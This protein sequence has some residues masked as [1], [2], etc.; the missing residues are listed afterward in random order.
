VGFAWLMFMRRASFFP[1]FADEIVVLSVGSNLVLLAAL[2][3][4]VRRHRREA[5]QNLLGAKQE[6]LPPGESGGSPLVELA[7]SQKNYMTE[8]ANQIVHQLTGTIHGINLCVQ[9]LQEKGE[10]ST[11][12]KYLDQL[13]RSC[14]KAFASIT[15]LNT[16][17]RGPCADELTKNSLG[18][19]V[20]DK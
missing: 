18:N 4:S 14:Q 20:K 13:N 16:C 15:D 2:A 12:A 7:E 17:L 3:I 10:L 11:P 9:V 5:H 19:I 6:E 8:S 1:Y